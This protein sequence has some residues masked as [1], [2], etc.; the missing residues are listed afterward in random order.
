M[1]QQAAKNQARIG[2]ESTTLGEYRI[3]RRLG[4]GGA[5]AVYLARR[6]TPT[7]R[8]VVA[9]KVI[10]DHLSEE[11]EFTQMFQDE[12]RVA[13][14]LVHPNIVRTH[15][16]GQHGDRL[17]LAMEYLDGQSVHDVF[18][19]GTRHGARLPLDLVAWIGASVARALH[20]AHTL[21]DADGE[22]LQLVHRDVSPRNI[23][24]TYEGVPKLI[25][26]GIAH[27][28][29]R[30]A[31]TAVGQMKGTFSYIA[32]ERALGGGCDHRADIF[33]L[34]A[35]LFEA[36]TGRRLFKGDDDVE[37]LRNV[38]SGNVPDPREV[39]AGFPDALAEILLRALAT[40][41]ER[42]YPD[43]GAFADAL[44]SF[45]TACGRE[46][47]R[48]RLANL[49]NELFTDK[50][51][52]KHR[53][54]EGV[55]GVTAPESDAPREVS[56]LA[57]SSSG[58]RSVPPPKRWGLAFASTLVVGAFAVTGVV[59]FARSFASGPPVVAPPVA[60]AASAT[61]PVPAS[62]PPVR[63][64]VTIAV[65]TV[66]PTIATFAFGGET[67]TGVRASFDRA[68]VAVPGRL[69]VRAEGYEDT[70][71]EV[72]PDSDRKL[73]IVLRASASAA[74]ADAP[75]VAA[76]KHKRE[77]ARPKANAKPLSDLLNKRY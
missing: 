36:G 63:A 44:E 5:A 67:Q 4:S 12:A 64:R 34:A 30:V 46:D 38:L 54:M 17:F 59:L 15:E 7:G 69:V 71:V 68:K 14:Q 13:L 23:F 72:V 62:S 53:A 76:P 16:L 74:L 65:E 25:D 22:A 48:Q 75:R 51:E 70:E 20:Y 37:T 3:G 19:R 43:A 21:V 60:A 6:D 55:L 11:R 45:V 31:K 27:A 2:L 32:P 47:P 49:M 40:A 1:T 42:R 61:A 56:N 50:R 29:G 77:S 57:V 10:H 73:S 24:I 9:I 35:T 41:P 66:P 58:I 52:A 8:D 39:R 33:S 18:V 28:V 26:F